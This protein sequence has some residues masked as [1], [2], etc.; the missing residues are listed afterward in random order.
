MILI[1]G[2]ASD[3]PEVGYKSAKLHLLDMEC[4]Q[5]KLRLRLVERGQICGRRNPG[6]H[7]PWPM[8]EPD[9]MAGKWTKKNTAWNNSR[10]TVAV[11]ASMCAP[12]VCWSQRTLR[13][14]L[15]DLFLSEEKREKSAVCQDS[16]APEDDPNKIKHFRSLLCHT[17]DTELQPQNLWRKLMERSWESYWPAVQQALL[18]LASPQGLLWNLHPLD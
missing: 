4:V 9:L 5:A 7:T 6:W 1:V 13:I 16:S 15:K 11:C 18:L 14:H 17:V 8:R 10:G 2:G 12:L 3:I